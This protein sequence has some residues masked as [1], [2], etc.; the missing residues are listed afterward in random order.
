MLAGALGVN[1]QSE[2]KNT[3]LSWNLSAIRNCCTPYP[4]VCSGRDLS[5]EHETVPKELRAHF[6]YQT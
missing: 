6:L 1:H 5:H 3:P 2:Y 4:A